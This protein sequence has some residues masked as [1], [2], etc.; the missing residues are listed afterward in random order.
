MAVRTFAVAAF[1]TSAVADTS[2]IANNN[3]M[4]IKGG[5]GTQMN[6]IKEVYA[7]G[8]EPSTS[9]P[10]RLLLA[11]HTTIGTTP[12][13]LSTGESDEADDATNSALSSPVVVFTAASTG[14]Q[15]GKRYLANLAFNALGGIVRLRFAVNEEP[16]ILGNT[17][18]L[19]EASLSGFT[20]TVAGLI[21]AYIKYETR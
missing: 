12:T 10:Q 9:S 16:S 6:H 3:Y 2:T 14:P 19:G 18:P 13:A 21:G 4:A 5:S 8:L 15:R 20:G 17:Q 11:R 7:G 1:T